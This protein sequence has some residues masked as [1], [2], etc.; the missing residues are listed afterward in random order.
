ML[1]LTFAA[2]IDRERAAVATWAAA[3][4]GTVAAWVYFAPTGV[5]SPGAIVF[6]LAMAGSFALYIPMTRRLREEPLRTNLFYTAI[7]PLVAL[8]PLMPRVWVTPAFSELLGLAFIGAVGWS[9]LLALDRAADAA[10]VSLTAPLLHLQV[11]PIMLFSFFAHDYPG[12]R[13]FAVAAALLIG[14]V[15]LAWPALRVERAEVGAL[16]STPER[17]TTAAA[18]DEGSR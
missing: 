16:K 2:L 4:L 13:R 6:G 14:T 5:P 18:L 10:P 17:T 12:P 11:G 1:V 8:L 15:A 9:A 7:V 3:A